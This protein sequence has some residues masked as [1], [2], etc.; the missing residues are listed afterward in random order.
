MTTVTRGG[1]CGWGS[2]DTAVLLSRS[3]ATPR[4]GVSHS[5]PRGAGHV[6]QTLACVI[7]GSKIRS[8]GSVGTLGSP[9][10]SLSSP[11]ASG[12]S[13]ILFLR[14]AGRAWCCRARDWCLGLVLRLV[15]QA[16]D[17][18]CGGHAELWLVIRSGGLLFTGVERPLLQ[19]A[20]GTRPPQGIPHLI[21]FGDQTLREIV[22]LYSSPQD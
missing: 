3:A 21:C 14:V 2:T 10:L 13:D 12:R 20:S 17:V 18:A 6:G 11:Q 16:W 1:H 19:G 5:F 7:Q 9:D 4:G 22:V 8:G 15:E